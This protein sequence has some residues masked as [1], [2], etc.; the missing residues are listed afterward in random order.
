MIKYSEIELREMISNLRL[1]KVNNTL[2]DR[3]EIELTKYELLLENHLNNKYK[4]IDEWLDKLINK[5][6]I[7]KY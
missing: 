7:T 3:T 6:G 5:N 2:T 1:W 4:E